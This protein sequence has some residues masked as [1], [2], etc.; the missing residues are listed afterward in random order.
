M[1]QPN[2]SPNIAV[3]FITDRRARVARAIWYILVLITVAAFFAGLDGRYS[4]VFNGLEALTPVGEGELIVSIR[5]FAVVDFAIEIIFALTWFLIGV[6]TFWQKSDEWQV[7]FFSAMMVSASVFLTDFPLPL[8]ER[9]P[10]WGAVVLSLRSFAF[11]S[12]VVTYYIFPNGKFVPGATRW[13]ALAWGLVTAAWIFFPGLRP[14]ATHLFSSSRELLLALGLM[15]WFATGVFAQAFRYRNGKN[16]IEKQQSKWV[17]FNFLAIGFLFGITYLPIILL[18]VLRQP[19]VVQVNYLFAAFSLSFIGLTLLPLTL[20]V[21]ILRYRLWDI[22]VII[23]RT[24]VYGALTGT[25]AVVYFVL[26][27]LLQ[28][29]L[30]A[31]SGPFAQGWQEAPLAIVV[32]TLV[33]AALFNPLRHR[34]QDFIDRRFYRQKYD[35][36]QTLEAFSSSMREKVDPLDLSKSLLDSVAD[37]FHPEHVSL[38]LKE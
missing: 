11:F 26:V 27:T 30:S 22:D 2:E 8:L 33:I 38:W 18:P 5:T 20:A 4:Y 15:S 32:S 13:L 29:L 24:L 12:L 35:A 23:N 36:A 17:V 10:L 6:V 28:N 19:G 25:L 14:P 16:P 1:T 21:S 7:I 9:G 37:T 34:I 3:E 31:F